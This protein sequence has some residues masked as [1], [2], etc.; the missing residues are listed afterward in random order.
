MHLQV[1]VSENG[2]KNVFRK[3]KTTNKVTL[4]FVDVKVLNAMVRKSFVVAVKK[5]RRYNVCI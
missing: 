3:E 4:V 1:K 2:R 5:Q